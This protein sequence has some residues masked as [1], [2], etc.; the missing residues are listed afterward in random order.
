MSKGIQYEEL[1][2]GEWTNPKIQ[3]YKH[4]CCDC[5]LVHKMDFKLEDGEL[6]DGELAIRFWHDKRATGQIRRYRHK[7]QS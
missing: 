7:K 1:S 3:G 4:Q 6:N 5:G 2:D